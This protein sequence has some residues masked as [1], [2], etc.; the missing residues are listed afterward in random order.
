[1]SAQPQTM[2][3]LWPMQA[4]HLPQVMLIERACYTHPWT[5]G[6]FEDCLRVGYS[7]WVVSDRRGAVL[8]YALMT[9]AAG[10]AHIL[11][12]CVAPAQQRQGI[13]GFL[14]RHLMMIARAASVSLMLLEV[15]VSNLAAQQLYAGFGFHKIGERRGYYPAHQGRED[16]L[17]LALTLNA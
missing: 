9:M 16:A 6:I 5:L 2:W 14:L 17:V 7:A 8:G 12:I 13:A 11:N 15:R 1:M 4:S 10:E 3:Q